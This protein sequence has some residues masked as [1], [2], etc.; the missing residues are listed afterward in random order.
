MLKFK[1]TV[2]VYDVIRKKSFV[3][4]ISM[5]SKAGTKAL[6]D[7]QDTF[8]SDPSDWDK[9]PNKTK[10]R[11]LVLR[12]EANKDA[13]KFGIRLSEL[14]I[15]TNGLGYCDHFE[16]RLYFAVSLNTLKKLGF[17]PR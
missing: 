8:Y 13:K 7:F 3:I 17:N 10:Y 9:K 12:R 5:I 1:N 15:H 4:P 6:E 14:G 11:Y 2:K 16:K